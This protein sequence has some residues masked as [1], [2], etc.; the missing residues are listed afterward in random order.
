[1]AWC[2]M[3]WCRPPDRKL[4][5]P[6][7]TKSNKQICKLPLKH[8]LKNWARRLDIK[9]VINTSKLFAHAIKTKK[10]LL[11]ILVFLLSALVE[12]LSELKRSSGEQK[13]FESHKNNSCSF[14][15]LKK[16]VNT[17]GWYVVKRKIY[18]H[19]F[20]TRFGKEWINDGVSWF[21][22]QTYLPSECINQATLTFDTSYN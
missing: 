3:A 8:V 2:R 19:S 11:E 14:L 16:Y 7:T 1:M 18:K 10:K 22:A 5:V 4:I 12:E 6:Q 13:I 17:S 15:S 9:R 20:D 21:L